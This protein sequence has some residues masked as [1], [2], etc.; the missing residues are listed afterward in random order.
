MT[1]KALLIGINYTN[2]TDSRLYGCINDV[3]SL[4][5]MLTD[6]YSYPQENITILKDDT[7][8]KDNNA[9]LDSSML[10]TKANILNNIIKLV[11]ESPRLSELW[12]H[13]SGHGS[14]IRDTNHE[15][16]DGKD[17]IIL[18]CD[19]KQSGIIV[20]DELRSILNRVHRNCLVYITMD[21]CHS[22]SSW[23]LPY[24]FPIVNRRIYRTLENRRGLYNPNIY[25]LSGARDNQ[26]AADSYNFE[27]RMSMGAFTMALINSLRSRNHTV[28]L[29]QLYVDITVY[30]EKNR[31]QQKCVLS[32]SRPLPYVTIR[33]SISP[34]TRSI[35]QSSL[36]DSSSTSSSS[37]SKTIKRNIGSI[38]YG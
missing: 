6:A 38:I 11:N 18:P 17:E 31:Y 22:G 27:E 23:D 12:I 19:Y 35:T 5:N 33:K 3:I 36:D 13:Y 25:M 20:D 28:S 37:A 21:C 15:E 30:L 1:K 32:S 16:T 14:Y 26:T 34:A 4:G 7:D 9:V 24:S 2:D 10:P 8:N 29:L